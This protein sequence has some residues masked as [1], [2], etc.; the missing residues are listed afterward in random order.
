MI[1]VDV[2]QHRTPSRVPCQCAAM[3][4]NVSLQWW[5]NGG[6]ASHCSISS[7][8][9]ASSSRCDRLDRGGCFRRNH[10][11]AEWW[12]ASL[13]PDL[14]WRDWWSHP[15]SWPRRS[16]SKNDWRPVSSASDRSATFAFVIDSVVGSCVHV[17][18]P[19]LHPT[20]SIAAHCT[21][22]TLAMTALGSRTTPEPTLP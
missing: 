22:V 3:Q 13:A 17:A 9:R 20:R 7:S 2:S 21:G 1:L 4:A 14:D 15:S 10:S 6:R 12:A 18:D 16:R 5:E 8:T 19:V 11:T